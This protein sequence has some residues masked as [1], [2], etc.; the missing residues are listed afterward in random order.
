LEAQFVLQKE[1]FKIG[2]DEVDNL[3]CASHFLFCSVKDL[4][5]AFYSLFDQV[6]VNEKGLYSNFYVRKENYKKDIPKKI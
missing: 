4:D 6:A 3:I 2:Q 5:I 1:E